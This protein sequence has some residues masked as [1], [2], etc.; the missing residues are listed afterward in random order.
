MALEK[1][2][3]ELSIQLRSLRDL[4]RGVRLTVVEDKPQHGDVVLV[5]RMGNA[6]EDLLGWLE[7]AVAAAAEAEQAVAYP[8]DAHLARQALIVCQERYTRLTQ[9]YFSDFASYERTA[10]LMRFG[11]ARR[12]EW[13]AWTRSVRQ[14]LEQC[15][16]PLDE[17]NQALFRCWQ[18]I[19][20]RLQTS[21][22]S[23]RNTT[24]GQQIS[25]PELAA[26]GGLT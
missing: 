23:I 25:A 18:E 7:E 24:I 2:F 21:S 10:E 16:Q 26:K 11:R 17:V 5:D 9:Q 14:A 3:Q 20:E 22:V 19:A 6:I 15:R 4:L 8:L 12:G 13:Q 1:T